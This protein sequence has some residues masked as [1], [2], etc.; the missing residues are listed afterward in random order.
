[1]PQTARRQLL[2]E[3]YYSAQRGC[4]ARGSGHTPQGVHPLLPAV[5]CLMRDDQILRI[6]AQERK[7]IVSA[8][9]PL[10]A[11]FI[12]EPSV[13]PAESKCE[14]LTILYHYVGSPAVSESGANLGSF[15]AWARTDAVWVLQNGIVSEGDLG[16]DNA[17]SGY[18]FIRVWQSIPKEQTEHVF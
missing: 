6:A 15:P 18:T 7:P 11:I 12:G 3:G 4:G 5:F 10:C 2:G 1:M 16:Y 9:E 14:P 8:C 17:M 13:L